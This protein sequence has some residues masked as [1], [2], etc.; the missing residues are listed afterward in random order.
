MR[1]S[2]LRHGVRTAA[3][4]GLC[5]V[6]LAA[7]SD[8]TEPVTTTHPSPSGQLTPLLDSTLSTPRWFTGT[9]GLAHLVYELMLTNAL[10]VAVTLNTIEVHDAESNTLLVRLAGE[11]LRASTSLA[12]SPEVPSVELPAA[13]VAAVWMDIALPDTLVPAAIT[14]RITI[15]PPPE[16]PLPPDVL[17][18]TGAAVPVDQRAPVVISPPLAGPRWAALGSCCDGP[19]RRALYPIDG[20]WNLAQRFAIDFNQL[21]SENRP[22]TG[23]PTLP[24]SF[25]T[26]GQPVYAVADGTVVVA[27]DGNPDLRVGETREEPTPEN[28]GANRVIIDIGDGRFAVYAHLQQGSVVVRPG[29]R[30]TRGHHI[31]DVG[32]SGTTGGPHLHFQIT[33]RPSVVLAD[34]MPYALNNFD[35]IG[36]TPPLAEVLAYYDNLDAIPIA[37][38]RTGERHDETPLGRDVVTFPVEQR[39]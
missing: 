37:T 35:L 11:P 9:D 10:P 12:A 34:G 28:A 22:G 33:D 21:D 18:Y 20:R 29:E 13:S 38:T 36:Q 1:W 39:R 3:V 32:S 24:E 27:V 15:E 19:H 31:A 2:P 30:I 8:T 7:C 4:A 14:H 17:T 25:P 16:V 6:L 23:D 26:Y 5:T